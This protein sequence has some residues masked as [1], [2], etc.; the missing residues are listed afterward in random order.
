MIHQEATLEIGVGLFIGQ[1][2]TFF[3]LLKD[4]AADADAAKRQG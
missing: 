3:E 1:P 4:L 2:P